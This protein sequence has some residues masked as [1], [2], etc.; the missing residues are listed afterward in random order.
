MINQQPQCTVYTVPEK[1]KD[2]K[3]FEDIYS[4]LTAPFP[5][6]AHS[7]RVL[8]KD[9]NGKWTYWVYVPWQQIRERLIK[10][11]GLRGFAIET[12]GYW[13]DEQGN[14]IVQIR[15]NI[16]GVVREGIGYT[17][18]HQS[19]KGNKSQTTYADAY[20]NAAEEF[21]IGAYIDDQEF[22]IRYLWQNAT[23]AK[24]KAIAQKLAGQYSLNLKYLRQEAKEAQPKIERTSTSIDQQ[25]ADQVRAVRSVTGH[26]QDNIKA[27]T[28]GQHPAKLSSN[29]FE[30]LL[31][32]LVVGAAKSQGHLDETNTKQAYQ[33]LDSMVAIAKA[34]GRTDL[35][36]VA[37]DWLTNKAPHYRQ[38]PKLIKI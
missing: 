29:E 15:L 4:D 30:E 10:V 32:A 1:T 13:F 22:V 27:M 18:T 9:K 11:V 31:K 7:E 33:G 23:D 19:F 17:T 3:T 2:G 38:L 8:G 26:S 16:L 36:N 21:G 24:T 14:P 37:I 34:S 5:P 25:K 12:T 6:E 20:K 35:G 28:G